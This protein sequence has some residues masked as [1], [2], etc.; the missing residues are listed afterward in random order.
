[1]SGQCFFKIISVQNLDII[2]FGFRK[3][4]Q[5]W[6][7]TRAKFAVRTLFYFWSACPDRGHFIKTNPLWPMSETQGKHIA[8]NLT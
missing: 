1:M 5:V 6:L 3:T 7:H 8:T 2:L 4:G